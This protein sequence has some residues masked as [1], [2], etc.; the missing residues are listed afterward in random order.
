MAINRSIYSKLAIAAFFALFVAL[1]LSTCSVLGGGPVPLI[2]TNKTITEG[3]G[4]KFEIGATKANTYATILIHY[5]KDGNRLITFWEPSDGRPTN[6][7]EYETELL[8][9]C[10]NPCYKF[11][12]AVFDVAPS[13]PPP[14]S[15][16]DNWSVRMPGPWVNSISLEFEDGRLSSINRSEFLFERP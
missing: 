12:R 8:R 2:E 1:F 10:R 14:L 15:F 16:S 7:A 9:G 5:S 13:V 3:T 4:W 6:L 11:D